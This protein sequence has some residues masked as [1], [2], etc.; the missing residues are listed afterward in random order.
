MIIF[1]KMK[2]VYLKSVD[3]MNMACTLNLD[4]E[5]NILAVFKFELAAL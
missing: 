1:L 3:R 2:R 5:M 4:S